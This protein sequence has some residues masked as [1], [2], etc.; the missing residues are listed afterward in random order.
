MEITVNKK[1]K[2][3]AMATVKRSKLIFYCTAF[4]LP[5]LQFLVFYLYINFNSFMLAFQKYEF[6]K[7]YVFD[8]LSVFKEVFHDFKTMDIL[9]FSVKNS[10]L[11]FFWTFIFGSIGSIFFSYYI[12]KKR[13]GSMLFKIVLYLPQILGGVVV[14]VMY[15]YFMDNAIPEIVK[16][17][18]GNEINGLIANADTTKTVIT[19]YCIWSGFGTQVLIYSSAMSGISD[20]ILEAAKLDGVS[21]LRELVSIVLPYIWSTVTT[22]VVSSVVGI[23]THQMG[24]YTFFGTNASYDLCTFGY[25]MFRGIKMAGYSEYPYYAAMGLTLTAIAVPLTLF[26]RFAMTKYGPKTE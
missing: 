20:S 3:S 9:L 21:P 2:K 19:F 10:L 18:S 6:G 7:G 25:F 8:G 26:V 16:L 11:L 1:Q 22:F 23:F 14:V 24:L 5:I 15:K 13:L 12:F 4:A 17:I